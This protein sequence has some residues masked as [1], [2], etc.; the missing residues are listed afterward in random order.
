MSDKSMYMLAA[1]VGSAAGGAVP[2]LWG[3]GLFS[4]WGVAT[5]AVGGFMGIYLAYRYLHG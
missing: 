4:M 1:S 5:G 3:A 2:G